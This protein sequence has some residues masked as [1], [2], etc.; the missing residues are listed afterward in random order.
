M[1]R[2]LAALPMLAAL[3]LFGCSR[4]AGL[5][6][7]EKN[8]INGSDSLMRVLTVADSADVA[9][10]HAQSANF[11]AADLQSP[12][13]QALVAKMKYT[14]QDPSQDGVGIA[15]P[16]V[17]LN[18]RLIVVCRLDLP[19]EPFVA[20]ANVKIDSLWGDTVVGRE[21]C[22]S[23]PGLR[24]NVPRAEFAAVSYVDPETLGVCRDTVTGYV[25]RIFQHEVDHL[26]GILYTD[27]TEDVWEVEE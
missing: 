13:Y 17:G 10:L 1:R 8:L 22:L 3:L 20:Y 23:V 26:A 11:S 16:Q 27:R 9:V 5:T 12:E 14:V 19:G 2:L 25:A 21:G 6:Q 24:G 7:D 4:N 15:A 18:R